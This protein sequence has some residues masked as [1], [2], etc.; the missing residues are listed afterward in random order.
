MSRRRAESASSFSLRSA[1]A[2]STPTPP[3]NSQD[4]ANLTYAPHKIATP[5]PATQ[6][7]SFDLGGVEARQ[8]ASGNPLKE[9]HRAVGVVGGHLKNAFSR[10]DA[11]TASSADVLHLRRTVDD[12]SQ[13]LRKASDTNMQLENSV[14]RMRQT[15]AS[16]QTDSSGCTAKLKADLATLQRSEAELKEEL[17]TRATAAVE[18]KPIAFAF[19]HSVQSA[20][21]AEERARQASCVENKCNQLQAR[22]ASLSAEIGV[23]EAQRSEIT[24]YL[25][26]DDNVD[27]HDLERILSD[28]QEAKESVA[29]LSNTRDGLEDE[30]LRFR[31]LAEAR[32]GDALELKTS[33]EDHKQ[34]EVVA[35]AAAWKAQQ[36]AS[37]LEKRVEMQQKDASAMGMD[38][39]GLERSNAIEGVAPPRRTLD[40]QKALVQ[41][42]HKANGVALHL[43]D[44]LSTDAPIGLT[45]H[46]TSAETGQGRAGG[47]TDEMISAIVDD[48]KNFFTDAAERHN[49]QNHSGFIGESAIPPV[50]LGAA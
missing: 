32:R 23:L 28:A 41:A 37:D 12:L 14:A 31:A 16:A 46:D 17:R 35:I 5:G 22:A 49:M 42:A 15:L 6:K 33:I 4:T 27:V 13:R 21:E 26:K 10:S 9:G 34:R 36:T 48:M 30:V 8:A 7:L 25:C 3:R 1:F 43:P 19:E 24:S 20:L 2:I 40:S 39:N 18:N 38:W 29:A 44:T 47:E 11:A 45:A 50:V